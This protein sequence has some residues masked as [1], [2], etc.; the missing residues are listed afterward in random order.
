MGQA[1]SVGILRGGVT[2][3]ELIRMSDI[4]IEKVKSIEESSAIKWVKDNCELAEW[5]DIIVIAVKPGIVSSVLGEISPSLDSSK[6]LISIAAGVT[7]A[8]IEKSAPGVPVIRAMPNTPALIN[9]GVTAI[10]GGNFAEEPHMEKASKI[11]SAVGIVVSVDERLMDAVTALSGSG[12][13]YVFLMA[14]AMESAGI[15]MNLPAEISQKLTRGTILGAAK[16]LMQEGSEPSDLRMK[17]TSPGGT[18]E[19]ALNYLEKNNFKEALI[20][21]IDS[22]A[23]RSKELNKEE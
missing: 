5:A 23:K 1:L 4:D 11:F 13:A 8:E 21:A 17:V 9:Q 12:P 10:A 2:E 15:R 22:A 19:A 20:G 16:M 18:T 6:L 7:I 14:E 3:K